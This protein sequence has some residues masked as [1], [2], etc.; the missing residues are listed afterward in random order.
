MR[1]VLDHNPRALTKAR[2]RAGLS[3]AALARRIGCSR[4]LITEY[5]DGSRNANEERLHS[6]ALAL[7]CPVDTLRTKSKSPG[8]ATAPADVA[9]PSVRDAERAASPDLPELRSLTAEQTGGQR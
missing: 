6:L 8:Q 4:S 7:D 1:K 2:E 5:E 9:V 3:K